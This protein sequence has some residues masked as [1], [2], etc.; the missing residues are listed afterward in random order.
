[1]RTRRSPIVVIGTVAAVAFVLAFNTRGQPATLAGGGPVATPAS[2]SGSTSSGSSGSGASG[3]GPPGS[4]SQTVVGVDAPNQYGDVQVQVTSSGGQIT[5]VTAV[6]LPSGDPRS[7]QISTVAG[8]QLASQ[9]LAAQSASIDGV[10]GA[11]YT[12]DSYET[13]LQSAID[14]IALKS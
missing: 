11:T 7:Q 2:S 1:M 14:Q 13:S 9:A 4:G 8:P 3:S 6:S 12:S 5:A 10:S